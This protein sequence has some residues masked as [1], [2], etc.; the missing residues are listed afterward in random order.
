MKRPK[1]SEVQYALE[2]TKKRLASYSE[3]QAALEK[4][5]ADP[6]ASEIAADAIALNE[7][8]IACIELVLALSKP[9]A[10]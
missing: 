2:M 1:R 4:K 9:P 5:K 7:T 8:I 10:A 3:W 6:G